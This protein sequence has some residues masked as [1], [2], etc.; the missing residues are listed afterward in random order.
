[1]TPES[2]PAG[3]RAD[4]AFRPQLTFPDGPGLPVGTRILTRLGEIAVE[5]LQEGD[6]VICRRRG[7]VQVSG[8]EKRVVTG[9]MVRIRAGSLGKN[10]PAADTVVAADQA[11]LV[12]DWHARV[13]HGVAER[14][15]LAVQLVDDEFILEIGHQC[16]DMIRIACA[17]PAILYAGGLEV[18]APC[19]ASQT[20]P[21]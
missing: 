12:R 21:A 6:H 14:E 9:R 3:Q 19:G 1:M 10:L 17:E 5:D 18:M 13:L 4:R 11:I 8:I 16:R 2:A 7:Y 20:L 15:M